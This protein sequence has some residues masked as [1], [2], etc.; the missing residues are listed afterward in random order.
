MFAYCDNNPVRYSDYFGTFRSSSYKA[1]CYTEYPA[2][3]G[4]TP[5]RDVTD[6]IGAALADS[7]NKAKMR[8]NIAYVIWG[9]DS[10]AARSMIYF[11]FYNEVNHNAAWD[12]KRADP[13]ESTIGT[14]YPGFG[15]YVCFAGLNMTPEQLGNFTYGFLGYAYN[16]PIRHLIGGSYYAA[17]FPTESHAMSNEV[18]DWF[19][20]SLGYEYAEQILAGG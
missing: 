12:I 20:V 1:V 2:I 13:W 8:C 10:T 5:I 9:D 11:Y 19:F 6:E 4:K 18:F 7:V 17:G 3:Q 14:P 15:K 16:I